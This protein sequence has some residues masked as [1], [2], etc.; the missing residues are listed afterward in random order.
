MAM[1]LKSCH[2]HTR[3]WTGRS[4]VKR[5]THREFRRASKEYIKEA[6]RN[7][8]DTDPSQLSWFPEYDQESYDL[9]F[10]DVTPE[11]PKKIVFRGWVW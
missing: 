6:L 7:P 9:G 11:A 8:N 10:R 3:E 1:Q 5:E 4:Y 2:N